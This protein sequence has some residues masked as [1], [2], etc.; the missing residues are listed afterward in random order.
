M[1]GVVRVV[2]APTTGGDLR[3]FAA[4]GPGPTAADGDGEGIRLVR[5]AKLSAMRYE[6]DAPRRR[7]VLGQLFRAM[8]GRQGSFTLGEMHESVQEGGEPSALAFGDLVKY[9]RTLYLGG[10]LAIEEDRDE[11]FFRD[12]TM[13]LTLDPP[14]AESL[15]LV[16]ETAVAARVVAVAGETPVD[17]P[18]VCSVLGLDL[19]DVRVG[20]R[21]GTTALLAEEV[22]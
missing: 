21:A 10:A 1:N 4:S 20:Q 7:A 8:V 16:Y 5:K 13:S 19:L 22:R 14:V 9:A 3:V 18:M 12:R 17:A 11:G 2:P 6:R 15:V